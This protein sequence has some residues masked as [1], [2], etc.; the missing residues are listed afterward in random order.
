MTSGLD[1]QT[2]SVGRNSEGLMEEK[3]C[4]I[5]QN[6]LQHSLEQYKQYR[7]CYRVQT[8]KNSAKQCK[9]MQKRAKQ[10]KAAQN[11]AKLCKTVQNSAKLCKTVKT[12]Q[13]SAKLCK[14]AKAWWRRPS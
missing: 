2:M 5:V 9:T 10:H 7:Q 6:T 13:N 11:S 14:T 4:K 1:D 8:A 12:V 3:H